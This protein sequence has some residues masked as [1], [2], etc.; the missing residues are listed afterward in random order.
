M[1]Y[2]MDH[3]RESL[4]GH[5][6]RRVLQDDESNISVWRMERK[7]TRTMCVQITF[8]GEGIAIQGDLIFGP[9]EGLTS[10]YGHGLDFFTDEQPEDYLCSKFLSKE[11]VA[12]YAA[13]DLKV[14]IT[15]G[16]FTKRYSKTQAEDGNWEIWLDSEMHYAYVDEDMAQAAYLI[17]VDEEKKKIEVVTQIVE[18]LVR[19]R[20]NINEMDTELAAEGIE[21]H[22]EG[23][24]IGY[25]PHDAM[26]LCAVQQRFRELY[27]ERQREDK[28]K[29]DIHRRKTQTLREL[30]MQAMKMGKAELVLL[31]EYSMTEPTFPKPDGF[32][33]RRQIL[34]PGATSPGGESIP[35]GRW[36]CNIFREGIGIDHYLV[37]ITDDKGDLEVAPPNP[38][39]GFVDKGVKSNG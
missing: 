22:R 25:N 19:D 4:A 14:A 2:V 8:T 20:M 36:I 39:A 1:T 15:E 7:G 34:P 24:G 31:P 29:L 38:M 28:K 13:R 33:W 16:V 27:C 37:I 11:W 17:L 6:L 21:I 5:Q 35:A 12:E 10:V 26:A 32:K 9:G 23:L 18:H 3:Y 30:G